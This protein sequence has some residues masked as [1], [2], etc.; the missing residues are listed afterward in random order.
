VERV[1]QGICET[2]APFDLRIDKDQP[3]NAEI[4]AVE[5]GMIRIVYA[6]GERIDGEVVRTARLI[7]R[8][9]PDL[10]KIDLQLSGRT[11]LG[12]DDRQAELTAGSFTF[13]DLSRPCQLVGDLNG[14]VAVMF[15]RA[16]LPLRYRDTRQLAGEA[17]T[18]ADS[19]LVAALVGQ[20][21]DYTGPSGGRVGAAVFDLITA[22]LSAR[23]DR[24]LTMVPDTQLWRVKTYI[25]DRL[26]DRDLS[27]GQIAAAHHMSLRYLYRIFETEQTSVGSWIRARRLDRCRRELTDPALLGRSVSAIGARWGFVDATHFGRAFKTQY[28]MSPSEFRRASCTDSRDNVPRSAAP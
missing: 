22:A 10:C 4:H 6:A 1:R 5:L 24:P 3:V 15:P 18:A 7:R 11:V 16:L 21:K 28:G 12:Q 25:E 2:I 9:D 23:L 17:F 8:S 19:A 14:V 13:V 26:A 27:P 20:A